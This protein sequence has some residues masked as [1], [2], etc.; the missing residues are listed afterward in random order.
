MKVI[1]KAIVLCLSF[2]LVC[3]TLTG[4]GSKN[5][6]N[7]KS[8]TTEKTTSAEGNSSSTEEESSLSGKIELFS[9]KTENSMILQTL[10]DKYT[11]KNPNVTI[12]INAPAEAKTVLTTRMTKGDMPDIIAMGGDTTY[13][14][15][16][17]AGMLEDLSNEGFVSNIQESY[18]S[19][20][21]D[22]NKD[23]EQV[24]Y[25][26]PY[27]TNASGILYNEDLFAKAGVEVPTTWD[28]FVQVIEKLKAAG[29]QPFELTFADA[30]TCL[31]T[32]NSLAPDLAAENFNDERKAGNVSFGATAEFTELLQK[33]IQIMNY[34]QTDF[35]GTTYDDGNKAFANGEAA[36]MINGNW[37]ISEFKKTNPDI[38]VNM[39]AFPG[40][41]DTN[42]NYVTSGVDVLF[43]ISNQSKHI[44]IAKDFIAF[45]IEQ[46]NASQYI[47]DQFAFSAVKGVEQSNITVAGVKADIA[48]G[49]VANFPDHYYPSGFDLSAILSEFALNYM[50]GMAD[51]ENI[52]ATLKNCDEQYDATNVD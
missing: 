25:G 13:T 6:N 46:E 23:K 36:M 37:A 4:C 18:M 15:V 48:S 43:T 3:S 34:A 45:M 35:M 44:D 24:A 11:E 42:K 16:Q 10:A 14:E 41:N 52:T 22:V 40:T 50:N 39:F 17:S 30:W 1:K 19:M 5:N 33:Y 29:I 32:W 31:P 26:I 49:K 51:D 21:Y 38:K 28:E 20:V 2:T 7:K 27:A 9:T 47:E 12:T 8:N